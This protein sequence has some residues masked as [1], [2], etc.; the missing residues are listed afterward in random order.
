MVLQARVFTALMALAA[1]AVP[2]GAFA[3]QTAPADAAPSYAT[4]APPSYGAAD[5]TIHGRIATFDGAYSLQVRDDRGFMDNV[6]LQP[7]TV[8]NPTG[9]RLAAGMSVTIH[10]VNRGTVFGANEIDTPYQS[11]GADYGAVPLYP[12]GAYPYPVYPYPYPVY[13]YPYYGPSLSIG[14]GFGRFHH[15]R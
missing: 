9:L 7:G 2:A 14:I 5:E 8:I 13:G 4:A 1:A 3:Q 6:Q 10:G 12:Y 15:F 11:Y